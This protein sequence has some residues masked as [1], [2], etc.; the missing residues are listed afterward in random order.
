MSLIIR[1][2]WM[3]GPDTIICSIN[4]QAT[5]DT[6]GQ[7]EKDLCDNE[8]DWVYPECTELSVQCSYCA[9]WDDYGT[10]Y[11]DILHWPGYWDLTVLSSKTPEEAMESAPTTHNMPSAK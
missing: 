10:G 4:G 2:L 7:I 11:G 6:L 3:A 8:M 9:G 5:L 1:V